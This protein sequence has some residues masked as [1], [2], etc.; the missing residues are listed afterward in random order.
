MTAIARSASPT[1]RASIWSA[2]WPTAVFI[3]FGILFISREP[4]TRGLTLG[5][6]L[7]M[8][9]CVAVGAWR[10]TGLSADGEGPSPAE[11]DA[12]TSSQIFLAGVIFLQMIAAGRLGDAWPSY[13]M[14]FAYGA[15]VAV[16]PAF[17]KYRLTQRLRHRGIVE[18][19]RDRAIQA[20]GTH[21]AK[22]SLEVLLVTGA[23]I[24]TL[25]V[26]SSGVLLDPRATVAAVFTVMFIANAIGQWRAALLYGR[27]RQ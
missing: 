13:L 3:G 1:G 15:A 9:T 7:L 6:V 2:I 23:A 25:L 11:T 24:Y 20:A 4:L 19:E 8:L 10:S 14:L 26:T 27:D 22:R 5:P 16:A 12:W 17:R 21:W 18:D